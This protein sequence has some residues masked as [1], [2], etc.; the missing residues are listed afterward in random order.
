MNRSR[1]SHAA[2]PGRL[3]RTLKHLR[4]RQVAAQLQVRL[5]RL[6]ERPERFARRKPPPWPGLRWSP[7]GP[8]LPAGPQNNDS[9]AVLAGRLELAGRQHEVGWP[10]N[11]EA[12]HASRLWR[13]HLH[14]LEPLWTLAFTEAAELARHW[15]RAHRLG[16]NRTGWD[17]YP[18]SLRMV[19]LCGVFFGEHRERSLAA[20]ELRDELWASLYLQAEW[21]RRHLE[22]HL[23]GNHLLE[24]AIALTAAGS[25]FAGPDASRWRQTGLRLLR[26]QLS[27]QILSDGGHCERSPMYQ[28]RIAWALAFLANTGDPEVARPVRPALERCLGALRLLCHPDGR[29]ALFNDAALNMTNPAAEVLDYAARQLGTDDSAPA[30]GSFSLPRTGYHGAATS[31]GDY[32]LVDAGPIGPD[33]QP[34]HGHADLFSFELSLAGRR[35]VVDSGNFDY[36]PSERRAYCRSTRA[37]STVEIDGQDQ[38]E[39]WAVFRVGRRAVPRDVALRTGEHGFTLSAWHDGYEHLPGAP[40]HRRE[41]SWHDAGIVAVRDTVRSGRPVTAVSRLH[42]HPDCRIVTAGDRRAVLRTADGAVT[43]LFAGA[44]RLQAERGLYCPRFGEA[45]ERD[46]LAFESRSTEVRTGFVVARGEMV[47][48]DLDTA[49]RVDELEIGW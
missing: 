43:V 34:G 37:H 21:L 13:Y 38:C 17:P 16:R 39:L 3:V 23:L 18:T 40:R 29:I 48:L 49:A 4:P 33:Y 10:P 27:E 35:V 46:V 30:A 41:L 6:V 7:A 14:Y 47:S 45:R 42:F 1:A 9:R 20:T 25:C 28:T 24:N 19:N 36:E 22:T 44:G 11:W 8:F 32:L 2:T 12:A 31:R 15:I 5:A 26:Q